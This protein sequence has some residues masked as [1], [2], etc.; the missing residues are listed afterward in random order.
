MDLES[1]ALEDLVMNREFWRDKRVL[2]TGHTGFK[3][4]WLSLWL[5]SLGAKVVGYALAAPAESLFHLGQVGDG[6]GN[7]YGDVRDRAKLHD[8]IES[9]Q[10]EIIFHLAAQSLVR[11]SY[12][13]PLET[14]EVNVM[15]TIHLL[16]AVRANRSCRVVVNVTSDKCYLNKESLRP[17]VE[18]DAL[19]G[20]DPYSSSKGCAELVTSAY[21]RSFFHTQQHPPCAAIASARAGNVI[22]G[23]DFAADRLVPDT[24]TAIV[25]GRIPRIRNPH[26]IRPWQHVL[27]PLSGYLLLAERLWE[28]PD[29]YSQGWNFGPAA[30]D[31]R[32]VSWVVRKLAALWGA[33]LSCEIDDGCHPHEAQLLA[34]DSAK[35]RTMLGWQPRWTLE[36]A[37]H[38]VTSWYKAYARGAC[39]RQVVL[40]QIALYESHDVRRPAL[41]PITEFSATSETAAPRQ[42]LA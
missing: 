41:D 42:V 40:E 27:E 5:Q 19:G 20:D 15:G 36:H 24:M 8:A 14:F 34:L 23:G 10:P 2:L 28:R 29:A 37:L 22:G 1:S 4:S 6:V 18:D 11:K 21:R 3:G 25:Q 16:E 31:V 35:A 9:F 12:A 32:P 17:Y 39:I 26:A 33:D 30:E 38:A 7:I 13:A